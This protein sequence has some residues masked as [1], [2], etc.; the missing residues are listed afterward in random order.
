MRD[1]GITSTAVRLIL[2]ARV[3]SGKKT[4]KRV[5]KPKV[6]MTRHPR[7]VKPRAVKMCPPISLILSRLG[8]GLWR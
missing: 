7:L 6:R 5:I 1:D 8:S 4:Y 2:V 3:G